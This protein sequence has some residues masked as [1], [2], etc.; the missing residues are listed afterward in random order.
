MT[1]SRLGS[2]LRYLRG[3]VTPPAGAALT[4]AALLDR[5]L[6]GQDQAA[7]EALVRRHGP[8]VLGVGRSVLGDAHL[9]EDVFQAVF[10]VLA[11]KSHGL[12]KRESL[13]SW[14][15]GVAY[16]I[17][18]NAR[19]RAARRRKHERRVVAMTPA[20][21]P[22]EDAGRDLRPL[23]VEEL[24]RLPEKYRAP[25]V[26][27]YLEGMTNE[28]AAEQLRWPSGTVKGRL[29]RAREALRGRLA[30]R[31]LSLSAVALGTALTDNAIAAPVSPA[32]LTTT[33]QAAAPVA[34]GQA[35]LA[36]LATPAAELARAALRHTLVA[37]LAA[38]AA[39]L[40]VALVAC[41]TGYL[42][43]QA[44]NVAAPLTEEIPDDS[45]PE[46]RPVATFSEEK[47]YQG[48]P[49]PVAFSADGTRLALFVQRDIEEN[50]LIL[51]EIANGARAKRVAVAEGFRAAAADGKT[52]A[53]VSE[54]AATDPP[55]VHVELRDLATLDVARRWKNDKS[56]VHPGEAFLAGDTLVL[57]GGRPDDPQQG[58]PGFP[59]G[60]AF[61]PFGGGFPFGPGAQALVLHDL[62][63]R[64]KPVFRPLPDGVSIVALQVVQQPTGK[65]LALSLVKQT[66]G[67]EEKRRLELLDL[68][69]GK[70]VKLADKVDA[71][72]LAASSNGAT[73]ALQT[74]ENALQLYDL[75]TAQAGALLRDADTTI[76]CFAFAPDGKMLAT[77]GSDRTIK[78]WNVRTGQVERRLTQPRVQ[79]LVFAADGKR[80]ASASPEEVKIWELG[81]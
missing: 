47:H 14:L 41:G 57:A 15:Y 13:G 49:Y 81:R 26:L 53:L 25:L 61:M 78:L 5:F 23:L 3:V 21:P 2:V 40:T 52:L 44:N 64:H 37:R 50:E 11:K 43:L 70:T 60:A 17:A 32:L 63:G 38:A 45:I 10:L 58:F 76:V 27:C 80:L 69:T 48:H 4:D 16:R 59:G 75:A 46:P 19:A 30:R 6:S 20:F 62:R 1:T 34:L 79:R 33:L 28:E 24:N 54:T 35:S 9:A 36:G 56:L 68:A 67:E 51:Q 74:A 29:A 39:L 55:V 66:T 8:M 73:A 65:T 18:L 22:A 72:A 42:W 77:A 71:S 31:G 12:R 7:F